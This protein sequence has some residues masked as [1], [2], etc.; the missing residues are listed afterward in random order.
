MIEPQRSN[1]WYRGNQTSNWTNILHVTRDPVPALGQSE[2]SYAFGPGLSDPSL[3]GRFHSFLSQRCQRII[4]LF[5]F[6]IIW[7]SLYVYHDWPTIQWSRKHCTPTT[8][9]FRPNTAKQGNKKW[10]NRLEFSLPFLYL[11][12]SLKWHKW[13]NDPKS[14]PSSLPSNIKPSAIFKL[15]NVQGLS[16]ISTGRKNVGRGPDDRLIYFATAC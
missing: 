2:P 12:G 7:R 15:I 11:F 13:Q 3:S 1:T 5:L 16:I 8:W 10:N 4:M 14:F 6:D 9:I